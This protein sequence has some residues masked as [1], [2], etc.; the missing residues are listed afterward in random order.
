LA[1]GRKMRLAEYILGAFC[2]LCHSKTESPDLNRVVSIE[3]ATY[4]DRQAGSEE[5]DSIF[6][7][8]FRFASVSANTA[9]AVAASLMKRPTLEDGSRRLFRE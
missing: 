1:V 2:K 8:Q 7:T 9:Y 5:R 3:L 6:L 4:P